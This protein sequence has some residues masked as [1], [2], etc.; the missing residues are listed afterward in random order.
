[1]S[2]IIYNEKNSEN[3]FK[4]WER[5][6]HLAKG[7]LI[8]IAESD[9]YCDNRFLQS[10]VNEF[11]RYNDCVLAYST[12]IEVDSNGIATGCERI[13]KDQHFSGEYYLKHYLS[14]ANFVRNASGAVFKKSAA[15]NVDKRYLDY[16]GAGDYLF[17]VEIARQGSVSII[18]KQYN[19][20]R[21]HDSVVTARRD[22]DGS[23]FVAEKDILDQIERY[24]PLG[25]IR[26]R[27][28][29]AY[30]ANRLKNIEFVSEEIKSNVYRI[31]NVKKYDGIIDK[32][33]MSILYRVY[34]YFNY[35]V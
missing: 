30:R 13:F 24:V 20:F 7:E 15:Y 26:K 3:T 35:Y 31:W 23:N 9:D 21:R 5:G 14:L 8:W 4:Q 16:V 18:N 28:A 29:Y 2:Q 6:I 10:M 25:F 1:M 34:Y 11:R 27:L 22:A 12:L 32:I 19:F 17:W 33:L